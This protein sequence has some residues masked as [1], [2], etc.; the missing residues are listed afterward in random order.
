M[1]KLARI[2][3]NSLSVVASI[4]T[5]LMMLHV[6]VHALSRYLFR[7]PFYGT[8]ELV[9]FWY[10]P[11]IVL[12][13]L[14]AAQLQKE[15]IAVT[16]ATDKMRPT[17]ANVFRGFANLVGILISVGFAWFGLEEA[18]SNMRIGS[19]AGVTDII[20]WPVY[21][22]VPIVFALFAVLLIVE[23]VL[24]IRGDTSEED[25]VL[26]EKDKPQVDEFVL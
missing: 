16:L 22:L 13:G 4:A 9:Q 15:H 18:L 12:V 19:T 5:I 21:F 7:A 2:L 1:P 14:V 3:N 20:T 6:V 25:L 11:I 17:T 23:T 26:D 8:N 24:I 10:L